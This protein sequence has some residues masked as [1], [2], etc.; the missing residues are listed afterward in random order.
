MASQD[1]HKVVDALPSQ[2]F[3][4]LSL[5]QQKQDWINYPHCVTHFSDLWAQLWSAELSSA[6]FLSIQPGFGSSPLDL[7]SAGLGLSPPFSAH[8][9]WATCALPCAQLSLALGV[10]LFPRDRKGWAA[11]R[12][13]QNL[14]CLFC[15]LPQERNG[16]K[17]CCFQGAFTF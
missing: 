17:W 10:V 8:S 16:T 15:Q 12:E 2:C 14:Q 4:S 11:V 1:K 9:C 3:L 13:R 6:Q 5:S 7:G